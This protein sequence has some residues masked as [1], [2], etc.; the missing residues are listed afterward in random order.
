[1][2]IVK[3]LD[4]EKESLKRYR[5][6]DKCISQRKFFFLFHYILKRIIKIT[7]FQN[8]K[9]M[10]IIVGLKLNILRLLIFGHDYSTKTNLAKNIV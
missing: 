8:N 1:M 6:K 9:K 10:E 5:I 2:I 4:D 3:I 7:N